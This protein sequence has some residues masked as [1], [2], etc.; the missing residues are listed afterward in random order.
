MDRLR[1][2]LAAILLLVLLCCTYAQAGHIAFFGDS[3]IASG[4]WSDYFPEQNCIT[5]GFLGK[6]VKPLAARLYDIKNLRPE[7]IFLMAGINDIVIGAKPEHMEKDYRLL[8]DKLR[9]YP[10]VYVQSV[11]PVSGRRRSKNIPIRRCNEM[12]SLLC[13]EYGFTYIDLHPY[14]ADEQ[15][16]LQRKYRSRDGLH[17]SP[18][19]YTAWAEAIRPYVAPQP[20]STAQTGE[21]ALK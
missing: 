5:L 7:K 19:G 3:L 16:D 12:L 10:A 9:G 11:L 20:Q 18:A 21:Y 2:R 6:R 14:L 1:R 4:H 8:F 13:E 17:L 15:G